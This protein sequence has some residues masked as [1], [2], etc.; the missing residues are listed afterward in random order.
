[1]EPRG[2]ERFLRVEARAAE[3]PYTMLAS[4]KE[5]M[6]LSCSRRLRVG[7]PATQ[8]GAERKKGIQLWTP[9]RGSDRGIWGERGCGCTGALRG[10][11]HV[12]VHPLTPFHQQ[13]GEGGVQRDVVVVSEQHLLGHQPHLDTR[14]GFTW[15]QVTGRRTAAGCC[16]T[17]TG[18][19]LAL[20]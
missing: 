15:R 14:G 13:V 4:T 1:M 11:H 8:L 3:L 20:W 10:Q 6:A 12:V 19:R 9:C 7:T 5:V 18:G 17:L 16:R 2:D